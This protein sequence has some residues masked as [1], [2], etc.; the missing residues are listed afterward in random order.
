MSER[1]DD[2]L[3]KRLAA[4]QLMID[5]GEEPAMES[6]LVTYVA[7]VKR[8]ATGDVQ[9]VSGRRVQYPDEDSIWKLAKVRALVDAMPDGMFRRHLRRVL[10]EEAK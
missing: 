9:L 3:D 1:T 7:Y 10:D 8:W 6:V 2:E 4:L 5:L